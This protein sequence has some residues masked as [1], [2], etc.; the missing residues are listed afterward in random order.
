LEEKEEKE[1]GSVRREDGLVEVDE[2]VELFVGRMGAEQ[3]SDG[4]VKNS[5]I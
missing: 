1:E 5:P 3:G 2:V 4:F